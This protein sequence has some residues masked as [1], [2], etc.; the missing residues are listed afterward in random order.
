MP[1]I[2]LVRHGRAAAGWETDPDP[3]LDALGSQQA[4]ALV[5]HFQPLGPLPVMVSP[6]RRTR[7]TAMPLLMHW[8]QKPIVEVR[9]S[10]IPSP[11][12]DL[13]A[14]GEWLRSVAKQE[15]AVLDSELQAW[16]QGVLDALLAI[17]QDTVV[18]THF[19]A[20]NAAAG[21]ASGDDR[22]VHFRP[23]HT[24]VTVLRHD[25]DGRLQLVSLGAEAETKVL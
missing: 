11:T 3:G 15:Y 7:E 2:H 21:A 5:N 16:R 23:N 14:R 6:M 13:R 4:D 22:V 12:T 19:I 9:V 17:E 20:I 1:L 24:S 18:V 25:G 10:E 8:R